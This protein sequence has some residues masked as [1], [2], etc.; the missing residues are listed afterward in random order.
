MSLDFTSTDVRSLYV[1]TGVIGAGA[2]S[3]AE[4][5]QIRWTDTTRKLYIPYL[6]LHANANSTAFTAGVATFSVAKVSAWTVDGTGGSTLTLTGNLGKLDTG[7]A[8]IAVP[9]VRVASTAALGAGTKT[10]DG[11]IAGVNVAVPATVVNYKLVEDVVLVSDMSVFLR[12]VTLNAN[13]GL[14]VRATVPATGTW[15]AGI[16]FGYGVI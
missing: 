4:I 7:I 6:K 1:E 8:R 11:N 13:E 14:I 9:G 15:T 3:D 5:L 16:Q 2:A 10:I 12:G